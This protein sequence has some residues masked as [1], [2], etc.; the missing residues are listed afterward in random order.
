METPQINQAASEA[1][2]GEGFAHLPLSAFTEYHAGNTGAPTLAED[3]DGFIMGTYPGS[4]GH[5]SN[6]KSFYT[7]R[8][9]F[10]LSDLKGSAW[11]DGDAILLNIYPSPNSELAPSG[12]SRIPFLGLA[13]CGSTG[14][15]SRKSRG[16]GLAS[17]ETEIRGFPAQD[18]WPPYSN[19]YDPQGIP[20]EGDV[21]AGMLVCNTG[22]TSGSN[23]A[24]FGGLLAGKIGS[25]AGRID[26][27][28]TYY[29]PSAARLELMAG[30][31][32]VGT[33]AGSIQLGMRIE[34]KVVSSS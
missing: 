25:G 9:D 27:F 14:Y 6:M 15:N 11:A 20:A 17:T 16:F 12:S 19:T 24:I 22:G 31:Y 4:Y 5:S 18:S 1:G 3:A 33:Y 10:P 26:N 23:K 21:L 30:I 13:A 7:R 29:V 8:L 28:E 34:Y 2:G 32:G